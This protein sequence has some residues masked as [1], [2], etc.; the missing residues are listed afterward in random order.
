PDAAGLSHPP[1]KELS[2]GSWE[3]DS[4]NIY[5]VFVLHWNVSNDTLLDDLDTSKEFIDHLAPLVLF[6]QIRDMDS[7]ELFTDFNIGT[8]RQACLSAKVRMR[9][10]YCL[11]ERKR[12]ESECGRQADLL[13]SRDE[14]K[15]M[16]L[17]DERN[18]LNGNV[19]ELQYLVSAKDCKLKDFDVTLTPLSLKMTALW[20][21]YDAQMSVVNEKVPNLDANLLEMACHLE[22]RFYPH[23]LAT[24]SG[25]RWLLTHSMKLFLVKCLNS[26]DYL[27]ALGATI[28]CA[29]KKGMQSVLATDIDHGKEGMSL[30]YVTA[31]N[32]YTEGKYYSTV[33]SPYWCLDHPRSKPLFV[34]SLMGEANDYEIVGVDGQEGA[35]VDG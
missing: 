6:A 10:E 20:I 17:E 27:M 34:Q 3:V 33:V 4:E 8:A 16:A 5:E 30:T 23:F 35:G 13:K 25:R 18:S 32:P 12:L 24:I 28:C 11:S 31:Y 7:E 9:S 19:T 15:N 26:L 1:G 14:E 21:R 29:I 22:E 2:L